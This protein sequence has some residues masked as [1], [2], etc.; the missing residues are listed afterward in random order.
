MTNDLHRRVERLEVDMEDLKQ[1]VAENA[2]QIS[3]LSG[4]VDEF[5]FQAQRLLTNNAERISI[6]EGQ[7]DRH[8]ATIQRL[9]RSYEAQQQAQNEFRITTGAALERID[10]VLDYLMRQSGRE[11]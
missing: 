7:A 11:G 6:V 3:N 2:R 4:K 5:V 1:L 10:R 9:D 8:E